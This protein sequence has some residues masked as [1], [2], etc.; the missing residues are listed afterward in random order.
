MPSRHAPRSGSSRR[1]NARS[2][3]SGQQLLPRIRSA[4][5]QSATN[6][7]SR[8]FDVSKEFR[9]RAFVANSDCDIDNR[10]RPHEHN[11]RAVVPRRSHDR[12]LG[13]S[14][15]GRDH[16]SAHRFGLMAIGNV[17]GGIANDPRQLAAIGPLAGSVCRI[18][19]W[20]EEQRISRRDAGKKRWV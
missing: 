5:R 14:C 16:P 7:R 20:C 8:T 6:H 9:S 15:D 19:R 10:S 3:I 2:P 17:N 4:G 12:G 1:R 13:R 18:F 11:G